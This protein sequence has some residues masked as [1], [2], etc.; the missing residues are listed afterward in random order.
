M[1]YPILKHEEIAKC[2]TSDEASYG[3]F[4]NDL[5]NKPLNTLIH[6]ESLKINVFKPG[7]FGE[8]SVFLSHFKG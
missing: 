2:F 6:K 4:L 1:L 7:K 5:E 3:E 8:I